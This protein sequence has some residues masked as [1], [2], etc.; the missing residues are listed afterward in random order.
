MYKNSAHQQKQL[1]I[2]EKLE[3]QVKS[4]NLKFSIVNPVS[5]YGLDNRLCLTSVHFPDK[6]LIKNIKKQIIKPLKKIFPQH[7]YYNDASFHL[8]IKNIKVINN[9][10][11]FTQKDVL[12]AKKVFNKAISSFKSFYVY[13]YKLLL[14]PMN[15]ALIGTTDKQLDNIH[16]AL[17]K[18][19]KKA[20]LEDNK[21]YLNKKYFFSNITLARFNT[22]PSKE[23][24]N[25][26]KK[27]SKQIKF[28]PYKVSSITLM[29]ANAAVSKCEKIKIWRLKG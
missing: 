6:S 8:T 1:E 2:I 21:K 23:F 26:V 11:N 28:P 19:L 24:E 15:L 4:K 5:D 12:T 27:I 3:K 22:K 18:K 7:Y 16:L 17:D 13:F 20:G 25:Q 9:P 10:P 29:T 14:F